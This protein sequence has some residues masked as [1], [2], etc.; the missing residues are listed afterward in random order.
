VAAVKSDNQQSE[1]HPRREQ[2]DEGNFRNDAVDNQDDRRRDQQAQRP[3]TRK[4]ARRL[5]TI[6]GCVAGMKIRIGRPF[7]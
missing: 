1:Q 3:C 6:I 5:R 7:L 2:A 4:R